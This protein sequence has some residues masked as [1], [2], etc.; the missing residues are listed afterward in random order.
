[1]EDKCEWKAGHGRAC[2]GWSGSEGK[3]DVVNKELRKGMSLGW[4][5][6]RV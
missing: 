1:M 3:V 5:C 4:E 6:R 2:E